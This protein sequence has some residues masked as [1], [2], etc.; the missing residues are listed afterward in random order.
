[1][2]HKLNIT[3]VAEGVE[4]IESLSF[5]KD[6][7]CHLAQGFFFS[8]PLPVEKFENLLYCKN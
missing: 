4:T 8:P 6:N 5:L 3:A 7:K 2:C 1:M